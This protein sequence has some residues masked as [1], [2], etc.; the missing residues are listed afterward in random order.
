M[1]INTA[2]G[3]LGAW[4]LRVAALAVACVGLFL[5]ATPVFAAGAEAVA[6]TSGSATDPI[7]PLILSVAMIL[8]A[9]KLGGHVAVRYNQ[10]LPPGVK[11]AKAKAAK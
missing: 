11:P 3:V 8:V 1:K 6:R 7:A 2:P 4:P 5:W 10:D 9:A